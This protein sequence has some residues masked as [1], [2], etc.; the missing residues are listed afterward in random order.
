MKIS[1]IRLFTKKLEDVLHLLGFNVENKGD[2][3]LYP[4]K[5]STLKNKC[6]WNYPMVIKGAFFS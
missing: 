6:S 1:D 2:C 5:I 3:Y 4:S